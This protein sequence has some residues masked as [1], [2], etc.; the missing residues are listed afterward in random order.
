MRFLMKLVLILAIGTTFYQDR[1]GF[2][3]IRRLAQ[4]W[5]YAAQWW[6]TGP[7]EK[8][9]NNLDGLQVVCLLLLARQTNSLGGQTWLSA[10]YLLRMAMAMG[11]HC[12]FKIFPALSVFQA[13]M[14]RQLWATVVELIVLSSLNLTTPLLS[15]ARRL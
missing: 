6:L 4:T 5:I 10:D 2:E 14:R 8:S 3:R 11:L 15:F 7:S 13:E 12:D 9:T 1:A